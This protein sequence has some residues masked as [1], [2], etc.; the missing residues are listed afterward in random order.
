MEERTGKDENNE[1]NMARAL[2]HYMIAVE[3]GEHKSL[4]KI[5]ELYMDGHAT[6]DDYAKALR[7]HQE[8]IDSI[9][10]D[11]RDRAAALSIGDDLRYY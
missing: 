3:F 1:A 7:S 2:Q 4:N 10:S 6:K 5:R 11:Q 9:K 8:Y